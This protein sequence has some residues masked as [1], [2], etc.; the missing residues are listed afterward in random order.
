[1]QPQADEARV[2]VGVA[3]IQHI[4]AFF[5]DRTEMIDSRPAGQHLAER[6]FGYATQNCQPDR[7]HADPR[8]NGLRQ[9]LGACGLVELDAVALPPQKDDEARPA[10]PIPTMPTSSALPRLMTLWRARRA[11]WA[12]TGRTRFAIRRSGISLHAGMRA[13]DG[14][15]GSSACTQEEVRCSVARHASS[16]EQGGDQTKQSFMDER[17]RKRSRQCLT[18]KR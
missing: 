15:R 9:P 5:G 2:K 7:L 10:V 12:T 1:M 14:V 17:P 18:D 6:P 16:V 8:P 3:Q 11:V 4:S 13:I